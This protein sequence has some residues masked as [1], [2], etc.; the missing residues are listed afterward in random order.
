[1]QRRERMLNENIDLLLNGLK[2]N[3]KEVDLL[4][5]ER[6][7]S[8]VGRLDWNGKEVETYKQEKDQ[9]VRSLKATLRS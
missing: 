8:K 7:F 9:F 6:F 2:D 1:M 3:E 5:K 4:V